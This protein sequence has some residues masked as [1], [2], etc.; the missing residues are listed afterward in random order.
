MRG[1]GVNGVDGVKRVDEVD[2]GGWGVDGVDTMNGIERNVI[3][4]IWGDCR[5][6]STSSP[7]KKLR[8]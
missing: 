4:R 3:R 7:P 5:I 8:N 1:D 6:P 2:G